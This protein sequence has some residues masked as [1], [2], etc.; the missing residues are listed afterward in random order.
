MVKIY[1]FAG[2]VAVVAIILKSPW[3]KGWVGERGVELNPC[4]WISAPTTLFS[5]RE[6]AHARNFE[7]ILKYGRWSYSAQLHVLGVRSAPRT[8]G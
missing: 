8:T 7:S 6:S 4:L 2:I 1:I 5:A 3:F